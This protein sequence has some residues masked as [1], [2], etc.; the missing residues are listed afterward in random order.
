ML[1]ISVCIGS[2]S[3]G[4]SAELLQ[5]AESLKSEP[6]SEAA[7]LPNDPYLP[8]HYEFSPAPVPRVPG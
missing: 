4:A 6:K 1:K 2:Q 5:I 7:L 3:R 8:K